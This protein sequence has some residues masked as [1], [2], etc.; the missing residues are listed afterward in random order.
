MRPCAGTTS[1]RRNRTKVLMDPRAPTSVAPREERRS[2]ARGNT[3]IREAGLLRNLD[4]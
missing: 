3:S 4:D 2:A 1:V